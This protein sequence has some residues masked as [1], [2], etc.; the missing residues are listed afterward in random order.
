M[1]Y[2]CEFVACN[3]PVLCVCVCVCVCVRVRVY[4]CVCVQ[5]VCAGAGRLGHVQRGAAPGPGLRGAAPAP[6]PA[7][8]GKELPAAGGQGAA[9]G[10]QGQVREWRHTA[11]TTYTSSNR[12]QTRQVYI[13]ISA[14][15]LT[16]Y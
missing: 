3:S 4:M 12:H 9:A 15:S 7:V 2:N 1:N 13:S 14:V 6:R 5:T 10:H 8:G 16:R 11:Y